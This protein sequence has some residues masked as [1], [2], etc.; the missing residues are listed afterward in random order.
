MRYSLLALVIALAPMASEAQGVVGG[1]FKFT[2][3]WVDKAAKHLVAVG[4]SATEKQSTVAV[5]EDSGKSW[6]LRATPSEPLV[7]V[8]GSSLQDLYAVG[9]AGVI[10]RSVDAGKTWTAQASG[11][12]ENLSSVWGSSAKDI[13]AVGKAGTILHTTDAGKTWSATS[14]GKRFFLRQVWGFSAK[15]VYACG[16]EGVV[17]KSVD[18]G[19]TWV[20]AKSGIKDSL[21]FIT[22]VKRDLYVLGDRGV[23]LHSADQGKTWD[24][25][26]SAAGTEEQPDTFTALFATDKA[27]YV[28]SQR[29]VVLTSKD[30]GKTWDE[31][32]A[33]GSRG[34]AEIVVSEKRLFGV[35]DGGKVVA[36]EDNGV[37]WR[38]LISK[39]SLTA[40]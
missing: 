8:W 3:L 15:E 31:S 29:E 33:K 16:T 26:L 27:A 23:I 22:G 32:K 10:L 20:D 12:S 21:R 9:N 40:K 5:S 11:T 30:Q 37:T 36:S 6:A 34:I 7:D 19:K 2:G 13:Y 14:Y 18:G 39:E 35:L 4:Y 38:E 1:E 17:I 24:I 28:Y 25:Y